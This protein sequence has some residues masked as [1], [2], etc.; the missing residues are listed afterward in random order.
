MAQQAESVQQ[1]DRPVRVCY[2]GITELDFART[3]S[4]IGALRL[5]GVQ[6]YECTDSSPGI[7]KF[8]KLFQQ[9]RRI[10]GRY[11]VLIV[12]TASYLAVPLARLISRKPIIFDAGWSLYEGVVISRGRY[13]RNPLARA[14]IWTID[15]LAAK[16]ADVILL[17]TDAQIAFYCKL[18]NVSR[19][20]CRR[21]FTGVD[22]SKFVFS[23]V[24]KRPEFTALFR[25]K[26]MTEAGIECAIEA[27]RLLEGER[28]RLYLMSPGYVA[29]EALPS[30]TEVDAT[31]Y[32]WDELC[33]RMLAC[34]VSL[35]QLSSHERLERTIP[36]KAFESL[37]LKMPYVTARTAGV[38]ELL[39]D[40]YDCLMTQ[41][42]SAADLAQKLRALA[43]D[44]ERCRQ[45]SAHAA[46]TYR[47]K[48]SERVL[49]EEFAKIIRSLARLLG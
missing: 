9:H 15:W 48:C 32:S 1:S 20:K 14:Y 23:E 5:Q 2:F 13:K 11:D 41:P 33:K 30:N 22:E 21:L 12:S 39:T 36:H 6:V 16:C 18:F 47:E 49:G 31:F 8:I 3:G 17:E 19:V 45:L 27:A 35:G 26:W 24:Q 37:A 46:Q 25:G 38:S 29:R 4:H 44:P 40:G 28:V 7:R 43:A 34:H 42:G 10:K